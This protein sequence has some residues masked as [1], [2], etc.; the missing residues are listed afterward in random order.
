MATDWQYRYQA[1]VERVI[2]GDTVVLMVDLGFSTF[3]RE[4]IRLHG[5][6][7]P[8]MRDKP[9]G[10]EAKKYLQGLIE[11]KQI[12]LESIKDKQGKYGRYLGRLHVA[13]PQGDLD[14]VNRM[15]VDLGFAVEY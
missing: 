14:D 13:G 3:R 9:A 6:N 8:E 7:A 5:I 2:D 15:M 4:T 11:G 1:T 12:I 10:P